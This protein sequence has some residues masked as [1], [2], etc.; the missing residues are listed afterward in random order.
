[1]VEKERWDQVSGGTAP[2]SNK[3]WYAQ[4]IEWIIKSKGRI[5]GQL[6]AEKDKGVWGAEGVYSW[7]DYLVGEVLQI[8]QILKNDDESL[9][10]NSKRWRNLLSLPDTASPEQVDARVNEMS[11][12]RSRFL[13]LLGLQP[14]ATKEEIDQATDDVGEA[15]ANF[16]R[17]RG[18]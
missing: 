8:Y 17:R 7:L 18:G 5:E 11:E 4:R 12:Y 6:Q 2:V 10:R 13:K 16:R 9:A 1:M 14:D 15:I 3:E